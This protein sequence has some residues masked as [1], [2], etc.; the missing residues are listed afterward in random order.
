MNKTN[1][2]QGLKLAI[3][4]ALAIAIA[5]GLGLSY[6]TTA[7]IIA[8][9][10]ILTTRRET[11]LIAGK[12][13]L[14]SAIAMAL[15]AILFT[16]F[17]HHLI[18]FAIF[19]IIFVLLAMRLN[20]QASISVGTVLVTHIYT[21]QVINAQVILNEIAILTIGVSMGI[22]LNLHMISEAKAICEAKA[23]TEELIKDILTK[24]QGQL[25]NNCSIEESE[26][27]LKEL[28]ATISKGL[29][30]SISYEQNNPLK[31]LS[32]HPAYFRMRREQYFILLHMERH[33]KRK[34]MTVKEAK[35]LSDYTGMLAKVLAEDNDGQV[36]LR[37]LSMLR[38][39]YKKSPLPTDRE[40]FENRA[41]LY[42][43]MN[44]L[45]QFILIKSN[46]LS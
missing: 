18:A 13:F 7:G 39:H 40:A 38:A 43:Y 28:D 32:Y 21:L 24:M 17:G 3:G 26:T 1:I 23:G 46:F 4:T 10:S 31:D 15:S 42:Q 12:R 27:K 11:Y 19:M 25:L 2:Y 8:L 33:F 30:L 29:S 35:L 9:L 22:V 41:T 44:D 45:E 6:S 20:L 37:T 16:I 34:F 14:G 5:Q 36:L